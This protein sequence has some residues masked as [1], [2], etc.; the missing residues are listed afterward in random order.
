MIDAEVMRLRRLRNLALRVRALADALNSR[1]A[2]D[3]VRVPEATSG[4][5]RALLSM[6]AVACWRLAGVATGRLRAHPYLSYQQG[7]G[8]LRRVG[9]RIS[10]WVV[11]RAALRHGRSLRT[12]AEQMQRLARELNDARSLT[13]LPELSDTLGRAQLQMVKIL[14]QLDTEARREVGAGVGLAHIDPAPRND[15]LAQSAAAEGAHS[16][17]SAA[18]PYLAI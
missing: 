16:R 8:L 11:S 5:R 15:R 6:S 14:Y 7:P 9:D 18:W 13:W 1:E 2:Y 3:F 17:N 10:A 12:F 4:R